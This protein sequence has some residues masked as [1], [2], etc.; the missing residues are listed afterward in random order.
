MEVLGQGAFG[1]VFLAK[2]PFSGKVYALKALKKK[3]LIVKRQLKYALSEA[4][5]LKKVSHPFII[6]LHYAFQTPNFLYLALDYCSGKDLNYH[7]QKEVTF[8]EADTRFYLAEL[9]LA[10]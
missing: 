7:I 10:L 2:H 9:V 3:T 6:N 8:T 1:K 5:V 4:N